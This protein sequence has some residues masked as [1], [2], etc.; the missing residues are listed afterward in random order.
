M[1]RKAFVTPENV[2][3]GTAAV[4]ETYGTAGTLIQ[5]WQ[6]DLVPFTASMAAVS[7]DGAVMIVSTSKE[8]YEDY[9]DPYIKQ[10]VRNLPSAIQSGYRDFTEP[11]VYL[12]QFAQNIAQTQLMPTATAVLPSAFGKDPQGAL[13]QMVAY[14]RSH[15]VNVNVRIEISNA[16]CQGLLV[17]YSGVRNGQNIVVLAGMDFQG[18]E[19]FDANNSMAMIQGMMNPLG[20]LGSLFGMG[21][22]SGAATGPGRAAPGGAIPFG[23][24]KEYGKK[25]DCI[26]WGANRAYAAVMP[27][28]REQEGTA[29]FL[30]FV[31]SLIPDEALMREFE[32]LAMDMYNQRILEA[33]GYAQQ[34]QVAR[35][36]LMQSQQN[37]ARTL[38]RNSQEISA[39]IMDSWNQKMASDSRI[40]ANYSEAIRGVNTYTGLDGRPVEVSTVADHVYQNQYGDTFGVSGPAL[41]PSLTTQ[42]NWTEI[43]RS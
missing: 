38:A 37:L 14:F 24:A 17:K 22:P 35:M 43:G 9:P 23:H 16:S 27:V 11:Y 12:Q 20:A 28:E 19:Y 29:A 26:Q 2:V 36:N 13:N 42:I 40:S 34:A 1:E 6:S 15:T 31:S 25:V 32:R 10:T 18:V 8:V 3:V 4:P 33:Q 5:K 21:K 30:S 41:D 7:P 39:G